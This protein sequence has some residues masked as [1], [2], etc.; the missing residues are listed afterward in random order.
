MALL[1]YSAQKGFDPN[2]TFSSLMGKDAIDGGNL[3]VSPWNSDLW[4]KINSTLSTHKNIIELV[5]SYDG[6]QAIAHRSFTVE[7]GSYYLIRAYLNTR[8]GTTSAVF[9]DSSV[10]YDTWGNTGYRTTG[11]VDLI[12]KATS[13][14]MV[15]HLEN[16][17]NAAG[18][19]SR[20]STIRIEKLNHLGVDE[21]TELH[22]DTI[23]FS[24]NAASI[25]NEANSTGGFNSVGLGGSNTFQS[26]S[27]TVNDG[28]Y[29]LEADCNATPTSGARFYMELNSTLGLEYGKR[30][31][32]SFQWRHTGTGGYW[33]PFLCSHADRS[34]TNYLLGAAVLSTDVTFR[35]VTY[36]W[37][38]DA[39]HLYLVIAATDATFDGGVFFDTLSIKETGNLIE[40]GEFVYD[41][42]WVLPAGW[43]ITGGKLT[44]TPGS[45]GS[46]YQNISFKP[47]CYYVVGVTVSGLT[48]GQV[49]PRFTGGGG[50]VYGSTITSNGTHYMTM[51]TDYLVNNLS[52]FPSSPFDGSIDNVSIR[53]AYPVY[54]SNNNAAEVYGELVEVPVAPGASAVCLRNFSNINN[55]R[56][57]YSS[58]LD[59]GTGDISGSCWVWV[60]N[61]A[62]NSYL[63]RRDSDTT[64]E[65]FT[66]YIDANGYIRWYVDDDSTPRNAVSTSLANNET[67]INIGFSYDGSAGTL[68]LYLNGEFNDDATGAALGTLTNTLATLII[69]NRQALD[70]YHKG[71]LAGLKLDIGS[72]WTAQKFKTDYNNEKGMFLPDSVSS[73]IGENIYLECGLSQNDDAP[74]YTIHVSESMNKRSRV[75]TIQ[76]DTIG[77]NNTVAIFPE[78]DKKYFEKF[79][80][81]A[82]G[83]TFQF[84][85][86]AYLYSEYNPRTV[87]KTSQNEQI[88]RVGESKYF[89]MPFNVRDVG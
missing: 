56:M 9:V 20:W 2:A 6:T 37:T 3:I 42:A 44:H 64:A 12:V 38:H 24:G 10:G 16:S 82:I 39:N 69:G 53:R 23:Y 54:D 34:G 73:M 76:A 14:T 57:P 70:Y 22:T 29:A 36:T 55:L 45:V 17:A 46:A 40:N 89:Q 47:E 80:D 52:F 74:D 19:I 26:Q 28:T 15:V 67:W 18:D 41:Q 8:S 72:L 58:D 79:R 77:F 1:R 5:S 84:D 35:E 83:Q 25:T 51:Q 60:E 11:W 49:L 75:D 31:T 78:E 61:G 7:S 30:Y 88:T 32:M 62:T 85:E 27:G 63:F 59:A 71:G 43:A 21:T 4:T 50:I 48:A 33:Q 81:E 13:T 87:V 86:K 68:N 65:N 66:L